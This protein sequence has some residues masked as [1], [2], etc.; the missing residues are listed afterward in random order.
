MA[1]CVDVCEHGLYSDFASK[2]AMRFFAA[3]LW[4]LL[5]ALPS[6]VSYYVKKVLGRQDS[7]LLLLCSM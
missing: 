4:K 1:G 3:F 5:F 7:H 6:R 2:M